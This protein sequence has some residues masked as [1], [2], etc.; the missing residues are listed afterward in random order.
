V[1]LR[2]DLTS[3][4]EICALWRQFYDLNHS[5]SNRLALIKRVRTAAE[6][7]LKLL[8]VSD[9]EWIVSREERSNA[10]PTIAFDQQGRQLR[11]LINYCND[12][13][14]CLGSVMKRRAQV[15]TEYRQFIVSLLTNIYRRHFPDRRPS[16]ISQRDI[17]AKPGHRTR[18]GKQTIHGEFPAFIRAAAAPLL[19]K[20]ELLDGQIQR[21]I[22]RFK[23]RL[24]KSEYRQLMTKLVAEANRRGIIEGKLPDFSDVARPFIARLD[25]LKAQIVSGEGRLTRRR[26]KGSN[27]K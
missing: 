1:K 5:H 4:A 9:E 13:S 2:R 27:K 18:Y 26:M 11:L 15:G 23:L 17:P 6:K 20:H 16:R 22:E 24:M 21:T 12:L 3:V 8:P 25:A 14:S 7:L 19:P 10:P